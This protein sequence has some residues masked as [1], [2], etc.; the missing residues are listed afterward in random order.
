MSRF[1][2]GMPERAAARKKLSRQRASTWCVPVAHGVALGRA[3]A[4]HRVV[5]AAGVGDDREERRA[6]AWTGAASRSS[7]TGC[8][9]RGSCPRRCSARG[10]RARRRTACRPPGCPRDRR[11]ASTWPR[12]RCAPATAHPRARPR[13][14]IARAGIQS[15]FD[16]ERHDVHRRPHWKKRSVFSN[17]RAVSG[18]DRRQASSGPGA[19]PRSTVS[20]TARG[21][22]VGAGSS[23]CGHGRE[24]DEDVHLG[25]EVDVRAR[26]RECP[27][28]SESRPS[29]SADD[30]AEEVDVRD[31]RPACRAR[32][33]PSS[34]SNL[35]R[36]FR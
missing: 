2:S 17:A 23:G 36:A 1:V 22:Y 12:V 33:L 35:S 8:P 7:G 6:V 20:S 3:R 5:P 26:R 28:R 30:L 16:A 18:R 29:S 14:A 31:Q 34:T 24:H 11:C 27:V 13:C 10:G 19:S 9:A 21:A 25:A 32:T 4:A 15:A